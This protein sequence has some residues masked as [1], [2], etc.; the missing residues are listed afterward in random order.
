MATVYKRRE[1]RAIPDGANIITFRG[2]RSAAWTDAKGKARRAPL[3]AAG[4]R[5]VVQAECYT[6]QY[7]DEH[8]KR[9]KAPTG[10]A[11]KATAQQ[12][13]DKLQ[14]DVA[15]RKRGIIT[16]QQE[17]V[18]SA[19]KLT[20]AKHL[21]DFEAGMIA[22]GRGD[23]H[24]SKTIG[25]IESIAKSAGFINLA[26]ITA[27]GVNRYA[28]DL[29]AAGKR[30]VP[31]RTRR[32]PASTSSPVLRP[33]LPSTSPPRPPLRQC[34]A[35]PMKRELRTCFGLTWQTP[36][37][38]GS[39]R[40]M[41]PPNGSGESKAISWRR[42]TMRANTRCFIRSGIHAGRGWR[43]RGRTQRRFRR[44]CVIPSSR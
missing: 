42:R 4:T 28:A 19:G 10:C 31:P 6:A 35:C 18:A 8:G 17:Q 11:D 43:W 12:V 29:T 13:A 20:L 38:H 24:V 1:L 27:D 21:E 30:P 5:I 34:S 39:K 23:G 26:D 2:K 44:Q 41:N 3:N 14:A 9:Q 16:A 37:V 7:S 25:F 32:T 40:R 36:G 15:L 33:N 22:A